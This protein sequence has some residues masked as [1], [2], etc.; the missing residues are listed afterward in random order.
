MR[1]GIRAQVRAHIE[2]HLDEPTLRPET[3]AAA[4]SIS[5]RTLYGLFE[6]EGDAVCAFIRRRRLAR[7]HDEL[8]RPDATP[9][10]TE[11]AYRWGFSDAAHFTRAFK[12]QYGYTPRDARR[13]AG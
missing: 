7:A 4:T 1:E 3:I 10:V 11:V 5:V 9:P 13:P 12:A 2:Q 6:E 8:A